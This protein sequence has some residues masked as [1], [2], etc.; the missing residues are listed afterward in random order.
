MEEFKR[1]A[2]HQIITVLFLFIS[3][4]ILGFLFNRNLSIVIVASFL[5]AIGTI[6]TYIIDL[7]GDKKN[8]IY[9][10]FNVITL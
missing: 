4:S 8:P 9:I 5:M 2:N 10:L 7:Q 3:V 6:F 1:V